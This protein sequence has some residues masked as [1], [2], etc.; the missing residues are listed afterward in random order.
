MTLQAL[1]M[2]AFA[3]TSSNLSTLAMEHMAKIAGT[4]SSVQG[5]VSTIGGAFV[6]YLI[7][8][9]FDGTPIPFLIGIGIASILAF[10]AIIATEPKRLFGRRESRPVRSPA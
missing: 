4:A 3:F 1:A 2:A 7:G 10:V 8:Q 6:G 9:E 5:L